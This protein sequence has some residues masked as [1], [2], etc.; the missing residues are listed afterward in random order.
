MDE[1]VIIISSTILSFLVL[2]YLY[3]YK[4]LQA[5]ESTVTIA[6]N[7]IFTKIFQPLVSIRY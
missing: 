5:I 3:W 6:E 4:V 2:I 1:F 7:I